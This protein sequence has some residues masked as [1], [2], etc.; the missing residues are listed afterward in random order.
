MAEKTS[1]KAL[2]QACARWLWGPTNRQLW[3]EG[4][5]WDMAG[6]EVRRVIGGPGHAGQHNTPGWTLAFSLCWEGFEWSALMT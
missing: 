4:T 3:L 2:R 6:D 5:S 1:A